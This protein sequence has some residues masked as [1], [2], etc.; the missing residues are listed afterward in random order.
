[1][2]SLILLF[3]N[4]S[5]MKTE[6]IQFLA[7]LHLRIHDVVNNN[8]QCTLSRY[9]SVLDY[10]GRNFVEIGETL[11]RLR[12]V[13]LT[14][15]HYLILLTRFKINIFI[16][17]ISLAKAVFSICKC[18]STKKLSLFKREICSFLQNSVTLRPACS[19]LQNVWIK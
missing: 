17:W 7:A 10:T 19:Y 16:N 3:K 12:V 5:C 11:Q 2:F 4:A 8:C 18:I 15:L 9:Y 6:E 14:P 13:N 1:M